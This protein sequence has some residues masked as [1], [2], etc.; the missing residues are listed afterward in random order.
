MH[1]A[2]SSAHA[3]KLSVAH[4]KFALLL[5]LLCAASTTISVAVAA[6][7]WFTYSI[8]AFT[9]TSKDLMVLTNMTYVHSSLESLTPQELSGEGIVQLSQ[10]VEFW[11]PTDDLEASFNTRFTLITREA[12]VSFIVL[13]ERRLPGGPVSPGGPNPTRANGSLAFVMVDA[14]RSYGPQKLTASLNVTVTPHGSATAVTVWVEYQAYEH[15]LSVYVSQIGELRPPNA[16]VNT[17]LGAGGHWSTANASVGFFA[18]RISVLNA[19]VQDWNLTVVFPLS[20]NSD[21]S[22]GLSFAAILSLVLGLAAAITIITATAVYLYLNSKY[23]RWKNELDKLAKVMQDLPG[24]P[25]QIEFTEIQKATRNFHD[26]MKLG[27]GGFGSVYR[28]TLPASASRTGQAMEVAVKKFTQEVEDRRY[29][30]FLAEVSIINR[31]RHKNIVPL[32][33]W[34]YDKGVPVL[35]YEYMTNGSL[36]QHLFRRGGNNGHDGHMDAAIWQWHT[37]YTIVRD[38][39]TG[40]H[41]VHHEHEPMVLHR[42]IKASNIMIDSSFRARLGDFGIACTVAAN[43]SYVTGIAGTFGYIAPD[44]AMSHKATRQTDIYAFGVLILEVVTGKKNGDVLPDYDHITEWVWHLHREGMLLQ[45]V[46]SNLAFWDKNRD[47]I[48]S[49]DEAKRLLLLG[50]ACTNPNKCH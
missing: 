15:L 26:T 14:V 42:D 48:I 45:A 27:K 8:P 12:P 9:G 47:D 40:L 21:G 13:E 46:D 50:L 5:L 3:N 36:D 32:V 6:G 31:L 7:D 16:L 35:V 39:A 41:Y 4:N 37:R 1:M 23:R 22:R 20:S 18:G 11:R 19:G 44:Y 30:D 10:F 33:G 28:C 25:T 43:K 34:S 24:M 2:R 38:V 29:D 49:I 17:S